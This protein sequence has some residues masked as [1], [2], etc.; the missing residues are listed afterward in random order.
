MAEHEIQ[1]SQFGMVGGIRQTQSDLIKTVEPKSTR[2]TDARKGRLYVALETDSDVPNRDACQ[3]V[4][5]TIPKAFYGDISLSVTASLRAAM[6]AANKAIYYYNL[7]ASNHKRA[8]IGVTCT[9]LKGQ[10][11]FI[12]QVVPSQMYVLT[13]NHVRALPT[14]PSWNPAHISIAPFLK[15]T[16]LGSSLHI[17]PELYRC[18]LRTGD[19]F[20]LCASAFAPLLIPEEVEGLLRAEDPGVAIESLYALS[21]RSSITDSYALA[22]KLSAP[23][24][25]LARLLPPKVDVFSTQ[26]PVS[27][28]SLS[29]WVSE[30][31]HKTKA[32]LQG[33]NPQEHTV[34]QNQPKRATTQDSSQRLA[35]VYDNASIH[36]SDDASD[37]DKTNAHDAPDPL[38]HMP[39]QP[40]IDPRPFPKPMPLDL[41]ESIQ[42]RYEREQEQ[43]A[44]Q[45][46]PHIPGEGDDDESHF[47][48]RPP[49][50]LGDPIDDDMPPYR[51]Q[52]IFRPWA[53]L[54]WRERLFLP[55]HRFKKALG[56]P[57]RRSSLQEVSGFSGPSTYIERASYYEEKPL[58]P[59]FLF[60]TLTM[61][62]A[63]FAFYGMN[64]SQRS[65]E[66]HNL[67]YLERARVYL[68][69]AREAS[70]DT[71]AVQRLENA[72][73]AIEQVRSSPKLTET[74]PALWMPFKEV[75]SEYEHTLASVQRLTYLDTPTVLTEHPV[76]NG[77][78]ADVVAPPASTP[79]MSDT[80]ALET[81][82][83]IYAIDRSKMK[84]G[85][86][87]IPRNG[88]PAKPF[89]SPDNVVQ[90]T[91][92]GS[93][94]ALAWRID[95]VVVVDQSTTTN[96]FGYYFRVNGAWNYIRLG[97][98]EIWVP[99]ERLDMETYEGNLYFFGAERGEILKFTSGNYGDLPT[100]WLDPAS[101]EGIDL[102]LAVDMAIDGNIYLLQPTGH[103]LVFNAGHFEREIVPETIVP[104]I[105]AVTRIFVTGG[106]DSGW[107]FM[108]DPLEE[109]IIQI[110]KTTG[111][112]IQQMSVRRTSP[113]ALD[114]LADFYVDDSG[115]RPDI[116]LVNGNQI[117][118]VTIPSLPGPLPEPTSVEIK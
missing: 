15:P 110:E 73:Q 8:L 115:S 16:S 88:G 89:L 82:S 33:Q 85:L 84:V 43:K 107:V 63:L 64:I 62:I 116:Y 72:W 99:R 13:E 48:S 9:V 29:Q 55:L 108:L 94:Q 61:L 45:S 98:S 96:T 31:T 30:L 49:I 32:R 46:T 60:I 2:A 36:T 18:R 74:N 10:D 105:N 93:I 70:D 114:Q 47:S 1:A 83:Y 80:L 66:Q 40:D 71:V 54:L 58:F 68:A 19:G 69:E 109:R 95:D 81:L 44:T 17:E 7:N 92:V 12:A 28:R 42:E 11:L 38:T 3:M 100:L 86:Y 5:E 27:F 112:I 103:V 41:G 21:Q 59:W 20:M 106:S 75:E 34:A 77:R 37:F 52:R 79:H 101:L 56:R 111:T 35:N 22:I 50:D 104:P 67:D 24:S 118:R 26:R 91:L 90:N 117:L 25:H 4:M 53:S 51:P 57:E 78:F 113:V 65:T 102:S 39:E 6:R 97:G 14:H 23:G 87:R 76:P